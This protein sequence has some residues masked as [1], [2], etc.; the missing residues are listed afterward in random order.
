MASLAH[1]RGAP[2]VVGWEGFD[3]LRAVAQYAIVTPFEGMGDCCR[4]SGRLGLCLW[5][6]LWLDRHGR[7]ALLGCHLV[8][9]EASFGCPPY[10]VSRVGPKAICTVTTETLVTP[11]LQRMRHRRG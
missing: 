10:M 5:G 7:V 3:T 11:A 4:A 6:R 8:A 9:G 2:G 1:V